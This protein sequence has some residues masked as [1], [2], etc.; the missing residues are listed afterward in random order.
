MNK[1]LCEGRAGVET[2][3]DTRNTE[4][5]AVVGMEVR[6]AKGCKTRL[7]K[8]GHIMKGWGA[9]LGTFLFYPFSNR[10]PLKGSLMG[11]TVFWI[12]GGV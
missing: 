6:K 4:E 2:P 9:M 7:E 11:K 12:L 10:R 1:Q 5:A 3:R 8:Q